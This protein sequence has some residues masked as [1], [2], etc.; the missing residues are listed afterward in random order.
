MKKLLSIFMSLSLIFSLTTGVF[1]ASIEEKS[2]TLYDLGLLKG[3]G[4][5]FTIESLQLGRNA[6][7][8]EICTTIV[9][10]L[11]K[12]K[13]SHYQQNPHPF[14]DV[15][16]WA[17][18]YIGWLYENYLVNGVS[19]T[20]FGAQDIATVKQFSTMLL[21]VLGY[22]DSEGDF[23]YDA[24]VSFAQ[25][26][27]LV[28]SAIA[29]HW[30]LSR[31]DMITMCYNA[32]R[33]N[34]KNSNRTL[35]KKLCDEGAIDKSLATST[36]I[37]STPTLSDSFPDVLENLGKISVSQNGNSFNIHFAQDVEHYGVRV[38]VKEGNSGILR[39]IKTSGNTY[40]TKGNIEYKNGGAAGYISDLYIYGL[41][42]S[43]KYSFIVIKTTSEGEFYQTVG[44]SSVAQN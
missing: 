3:T 23:S 27:G 26:K 7:R 37:L 18:D 33:L 8:A 42:I 5:E 10:M 4:S 29:S 13:K 36:G 19:N 15:P 6:T 17:S 21:R 35:A 39:E 1:G 28:D 31:S 22:S 11:G 16:A 25:N 41:D 12:E 24:A 9:R 20:Y 34:I 14:S 44:K 40:F 38:F 32:L 30:E 2:K 43:K